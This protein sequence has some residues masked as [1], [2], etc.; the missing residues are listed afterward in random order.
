MATR[1]LLR[2]DHPRIGTK[3]GRLSFGWS[4]EVALDRRP[5]DADTPSM[6]QPAV[7]GADGE[8]AA[9][10][11]TVAAQAEHREFRSFLRAAA[12]LAGGRQVA[13]LAFVGVVLVLPNF[14]H[15]A[16][17]EQFLWAYYGCLIMT[18]VGGL[19]FERAAGLAVTRNGGDGRAA[20][21]PLVAM[22]LLTLPIEALGL[23]AILR[24]VGVD[25]PVWTFVAT[26]AWIIGIQIQLPAFSALRSTGR[27]AI[28]PTIWIAMRLV[29]APLL[30]GL[31][32]SG[33]SATG[34]VVSVAVVEC[35]GAIVS[36]VALPGRWRS[37]SLRFTALE[38]PWRTMSAFAF[39]ELTGIAYLRA[40]L[41][42]VGRILGPAVGAIYGLVSRLIDGLLGMQNAVSLWL[43]ADSAQRVSAGDDITESPV[44]L[45]ALSLFPRLAVACSFV[46]IVGAGWLAHLVPSLE[47]AV[48]TMR[49]LLVALPL[50]V[51]S[52][53]ETYTR[54]AA[55]RNRLIVLITLCGLVV[56]VGL[57]VV[58]LSTIGLVGAGWALIGSELLQVLVLVRVSNARERKLLRR[59]VPETLTWCVGLLL[60]AVGANARANVVV[61]IA[62][63]GLLGAAVAMLVRRRPLAEVTA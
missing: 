25:L 62:L 57:N 21:L 7:I 33:A 39:I 19:G 37:G 1:A 50:F 23:W 34:L 59:V 56:N 24:F 38:L 3:S 31:A 20:I 43:F 36:M 16:A 49:L 26:M 44:R 17:V 47:P 9:D 63:L 55:G 11:D 5:S 18:S 14:G 15:A 54:S 53:V 13:A 51:L 29:E 35:A 10:V 46:G 61:A 41:L 22:R 4:V 52:A 40:D 58:L 32:A 28:E 6:S 27:R 48:G 45:R 2:I 42:L 30:L 60:V 8:P 12:M